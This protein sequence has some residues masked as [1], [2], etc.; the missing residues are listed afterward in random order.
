MEWPRTSPAP[1]GRKTIARRRKPLVPVKPRFQQPR[2]GES[3]APSGL[4]NMHFA[5][6]PGACAPGYFLSPLRGYYIDKTPAPVE[7]CLATTNGCLD[8]TLRVASRAGV[9]SYG[10]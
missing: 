6:S 3:V 10:G 8:P 7:Q 1:E 9:H 4:E 5:S 2:R